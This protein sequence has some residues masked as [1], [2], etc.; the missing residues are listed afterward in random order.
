MPV[1]QGNDNAVAELLKDL[2]IVQ[3]GLAGVPQQSIRGILGCDINRVNKVV[4]H[5]K[6]K[7]GRKESP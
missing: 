1:R 5:L 4:R 3:L 7:S 6:I 2:I